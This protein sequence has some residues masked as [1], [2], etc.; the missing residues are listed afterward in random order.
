MPRFIGQLRCQLR[1]QLRRPLCGL[2]LYPLLL[3]LTAATLPAQAA[4]FP[5]GERPIRLAFYDYG[6]FYFQQDGISQG[7]DKD[8]VNELQKR[9]G[10]R[11]NMQVMARARIWADLASGALDA[12]VSGIQTPE[13]DQFAWFIPYLSMKNYAIVS[14][15]QEGRR[16]THGQDFIA[17]PRLKFGVVRAFKHG[18]EQD[19]WLDQLRA[20][21]RVEES[22]DVDTL[23]RKLKNRRIHGLFSQPPVFRKKIRELGLQQNLIVHDWTPHEKGVPHGLILAKSHFSARD[24]EQWRTLINNMHTD[25]TLQRIYQRYL[26]DDEAARLLDY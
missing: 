19:H 6:F 15:D 9:S 10:C 4:E 14:A 2:L 1:C 23:F 24:A 3:L 25:G 13:R 22:T 16:L 12:S 20:Q 11:F 17:N 8:I 21:Q 26:P 18:S 5:C 7:I